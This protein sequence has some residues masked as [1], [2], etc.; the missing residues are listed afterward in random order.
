MLRG[1]I[2]FENQKEKHVSFL[3]VTSCN[4]KIRAE[5]SNEFGTY[6][7]KLNPIALSVF[8]QPCIFL[9]SLLAFSDFEP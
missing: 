2:S 4:S 9:K 8:Y 6:R 1:V 7:I 5:Q 3:C